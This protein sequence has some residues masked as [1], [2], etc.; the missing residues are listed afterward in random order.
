LAAVAT[1]VEG[2]GVSAATFFC[3]C[4]SPLLLSSQPVLIIVNCEEEVS[5]WKPPSGVKQRWMMMVWF[6][7]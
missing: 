4:W 3:C 6:S 7:S 5:E 2:V 1:V